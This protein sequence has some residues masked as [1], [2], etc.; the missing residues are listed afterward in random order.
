MN[1]CSGVG[2][3]EHDLS[4]RI[5]GGQGASA[6]LA[7]AVGPHQASGE[8]KPELT[9]APRSDDRGRENSGRL[10]LR[11]AVEGVLARGAD[12]LAPSTLRTDDA[13]NFRKS[14]KYETDEFFS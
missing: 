6:D 11:T 12:A 8:G 7:G 10:P 5:Q 3:R 2:A 9:R 13:H 1:R 4:K 14:H